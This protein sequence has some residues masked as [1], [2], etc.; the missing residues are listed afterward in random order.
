MTNRGA[1]AADVPVVVVV[2]RR[3]LGKSRWIRRY[4]EPVQ[5][6][7][8]VDSM[9]EYPGAD[10]WN[11]ADLVDWHTRGGPRARRWRVRLRDADVGRID[12]ALAACWDWGP[13]VVVVDEAQRFKGSGPKDCTPGL[14]GLLDV[15][16]H[17]GVA[18]VGAARRA[19]E[20]PVNL[21]ANASRWVAFATSEAA[22]LSLMRRAM[23]W[24]YDAVC[25]LRGHDYVDVDMMNGTAR[26]HRFPHLYR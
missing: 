19:H 6:L 5:R 16:R 22:D 12:D 25:S 1:T 21:R 24:A 4:V 7:F 10:V 18:V 11:A 26:V 20:L 2:G 9:G 23:P 3:G 14:R 17:R 13:C 8:C 15:G